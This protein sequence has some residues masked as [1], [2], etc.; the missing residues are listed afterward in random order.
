MRYSSNCSILIGLIVTGVAPETTE[1]PVDV[2]FVVAVVVV[3]SAEEHIGVADVLA[4]VI[5]MLE[6]ETQTFSSADICF[7]FHPVEGISVRSFLTDLIPP[8]ALV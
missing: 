6:S 3:A 5:V 4:S 7:T 8:E 1:F 2:I